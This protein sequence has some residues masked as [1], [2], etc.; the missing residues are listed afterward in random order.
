MLQAVR[1]G[2]DGQIVKQYVPGLPHTV[3]NLLQQ[4]PA[5][6]VS[7]RSSRYS[8][9]GGGGSRL[10]VVVVVSSTCSSVVVVSS[11]CSSS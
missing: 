7:T 9:S 1:I 5:R 11:T 8:G 4:Q 2:P 3:L 10:V 6:D